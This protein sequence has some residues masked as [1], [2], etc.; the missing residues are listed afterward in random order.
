L[1]WSK[2]SRGSNLTTQFRLVPRLRARGFRSPL[3]VH[4]HE[5]CLSKRRD[6]YNLPHSY[7]DK[8]QQKISCDYH[9]KLRAHYSLSE[10]F[11][12]N[13]IFSP[14]R[15]CNKILF[16]HKACKIS[17]NFYRTIELKKYNAQSIQTYAQKSGNNRFELLMFDHRLKTH[18]D[19]RG[20]PY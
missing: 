12:P 14:T 20:C 7:I 13:Y 9:V 11:I 18:V 5:W 6:S 1:P 4:L 2:N 10:R 19:K 15:I 16:I 17:Y 3:P 8:G